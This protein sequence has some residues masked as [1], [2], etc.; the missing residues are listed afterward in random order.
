MYL[1]HLFLGCLVSL[2]VCSVVQ[3]PLD[4]IARLFCQFWDN[5]NSHLHT[6]QSGPESRATDNGVISSN[7][8]EVPQTGAINGYPVAMDNMAFTTL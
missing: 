7:N 8:S 2:A 1:G 3:T 4:N 5:S 6:E